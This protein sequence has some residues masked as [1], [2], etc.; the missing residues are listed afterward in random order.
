MAELTSSNL[1]VNTSIIEA[2]DGSIAE[3]L[4]ATSYF[5]DYLFR[6]LSDLVAI[7]DEVTTSS[8]TDGDNLGAGAEVFAQKDST[9]LE[10]RTLTSADGSVT[11][12]QSAD[13]ID[14]AAAQLAGTV[15]NAILTFNLGTGEYTELPEFTVSW[16][17]GVATIS[18]EDDAGVLQSAITIDADA[19]LDLFHDGT[20]T[21]RTATA[22]SGGLFANNQDTGVGFERVL[23]TADLGAGGALPASTVSGSLLVGN[24]TGWDELPEV[25]MN[26]VAGVL[27]MSVLDDSS[28]LQTA[29]TADADSGGFGLHTDG[30]KAFSTTTIGGALFPSSNAADNL[31][32]L[33]FLT[34]AGASQGLIGLEGSNVFRIK[35]QLDGENV[36]LEAADSASANHS[37]VV[38][39]PDAGVEQYFDNVK[40]VETIADGINIFGASSNPQVRLTTGVLLRG[41]M[42][43]NDA[44]NRTVLDAREI[45]SGIA[46]FGTNSGD[47]LASLADF[48]PNGATDLTFAQVVTLQTTL[49]GIQVTGSGSNLGGIELAAGTGIDTFINFEEATTAVAQIRWDASADIFGFFNQVAGGTIEFGDALGG[50]LM[51]LFND[52]GSSDLYFD[53]DLAMGTDA[54]G[55]FV[56][57]TSGDDPRLSLRDDSA[58]ALSFLEHIGVSFIARWQSIQD[59]AILHIDGRDA[60]SESQVMAT[61]DPDG[62]VGLYFTNGTGD[63]RVL[64]SA[65]GGIEVHGQAG[66]V[67]P[68]ISL[69]DQGGGELQYTMQ[70]VSGSVEHRA[71]LSLDDIDFYTMDF[72]ESPTFHLG[73]RLVAESGSGNNDSFVN[74]F[75]D[76]DDVA[77]TVV[78]TEGSWEFKTEQTFIGDAADTY[79]EALAIKSLVP[80]VVN[81][82]TG[83][84]EISTTAQTLNLDDETLVDPSGNYALAADVVT[85]L[86][87]GIYWVHA[88]CT[89]D[90]SDNGAGV[91]GGFIVQIILNGA[92]TPIANMLGT[93]YW[94]ESTGLIS[95]Q[96]SG[97]IILAASDTLEV[98][99]FSDATVDTHLTEA[100]ASNLSILRIG[101]DY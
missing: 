9:I 87:A 28:A 43:Y 21:A 98:E 99:F 74:L 79:N 64:Q 50:N 12:V 31:V 29:F 10:F 67:N 3:S 58:T 52:G 40:T 80:Y 62:G 17:G 24:P 71:Q 101:A 4:I 37:L 89:V 75:F 82:S 8:V 5:E 7:N 94:R 92:A 78:S 2:A 84:Q 66:Q 57:D 42:F 26:W 16:S 15:A 30:V 88:Q 93:T 91:R 44:T 39:D 72:D 25:T 97:F 53:G 45:S 47:T 27:T 68:I 20:T 56:Q 38:G 61:F 100:D 35:N 77:Q 32:L 86:V 48:D 6:L 18:V 19:A 83:G 46:L 76:N 34:T 22:A 60:S 14:L 70:H 23:T 81:D 95:T 41:I 49:N 65:D 59:G 63:E 55:G 36:S 1:D 13:E 11:I 90:F 54:R 33:Q 73:L 51:A 85:I 96:V 69:L